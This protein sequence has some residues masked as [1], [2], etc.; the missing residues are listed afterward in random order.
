MDKH[1]DQAIEEEEFDV[2]EEVEDVL[3]ELFSALQ[4][5]VGAL[6]NLI[7]CSLIHQL[8]RIPSFV[9]PPPRVLLVLQ[10]DYLQTLPTKFSTP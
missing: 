5:R 7:N 1:T 10:S 6:L 2:P 9:G 8:H 3:G 4:D